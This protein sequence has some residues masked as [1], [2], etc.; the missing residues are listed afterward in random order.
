MSATVV[1]G[2]QWGDEGKG[3]IIDILSEKADLIVRYQ[4]GNNAGHTVVVNNT[5]FVFHLVPSGILHNK[6]C[7]LGSGVVIDPAGLIGEIAE[8]RKRGITIDRKNFFI[9]REAHIV[10]PYHKLSEQLTEERERSRIGTT[11]K[12]IGPAY[13][14]KMA[15]VGIRMCD[16]VNP[17]IFKE[18]LN[19]HLKDINLIFRKIYN[20]RGFDSKSILDKYA[21]YA[22]ILGE[23]ISDTSFLVN[24][25]IDTG[26][27]VLF[28]GAQGTLLD[29]DF[30]TYPFVTSS[31]PIAG[32]ACIGV[33]VGPTKIDRVLGVA[34]A[35]ST[36]VGDGPFPTEFA[37]KSRQDAFRVKGGEYGAT[38]GRPRRC[39]WFDAVAVRYAARIN[40]LH[41]L[42]ITKLDVLDDLSEINICIGY[43][44]KGKVLNDFPTQ[45]EVI[46]EVRPVYE[47]LKG[48]QQYIS[49][50]KDLKSLP[51]NARKCLNRIS[52]LV[53]VPISI[54]S[55]GA[56]REQ[57]IFL[58]KV[59]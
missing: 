6:K 56:R 14:D 7:V 5:Q 2:A 49:G 45:T 42:A 24:G 30:G 43:K 26:K 21:E 3:K 54:I 17:R 28:E 36:R 1:I 52:Y 23:Y 10:M 40:G 25:A 50:A 58:K 44:Y 27:E 29:V 53:G 32:G 51:T 9:S 47:T 12:G 8:L 59:I 34:K 48:W 16:L 15:R 57:T 20:R 19:E 22:N 33:G 41:S 39:G 4:G 35:Y 46:R 31:H 55:V 37:K 11:R 38:T 13:V 18:K